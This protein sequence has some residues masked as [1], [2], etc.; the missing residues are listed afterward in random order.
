MERAEWE[1]WVEAEFRRLELEGWFA[2][3]CHL[4][5][6]HEVASAAVRAFVLRH[7]LESH[8]ERWYYPSQPLDGFRTPVDV[9]LITNSGGFVFD[10]CTPAARARREVA[11]HYESVAARQ[12]GMMVFVVA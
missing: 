6:D 3:M 11:E 4:M 5:C 8:D 2:K 1:A 9:I 12:K 10:V 7:M